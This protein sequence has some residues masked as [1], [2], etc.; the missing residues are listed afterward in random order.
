MVTMSDIE[1][2]NLIPAEIMQPQKEKRQNS[3]YR[4]TDKTQTSNITGTT[5]Q[6]ITVCLSSSPLLKR[7]EFLVVPKLVYE[8]S[9]GDIWASYEIGQYNGKKKIF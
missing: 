2:S 3:Q 1:R 8:P 5:T 7:F 6:F 4:T 9:F